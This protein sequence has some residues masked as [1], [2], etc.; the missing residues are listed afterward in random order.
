V[1]Y[2]LLRLLRDGHR[3]LVVLS[4]DDQSIYAFRRADVHFVRPAAAMTAI[5]GALIDVRSSSPTMG[6]LYGGRYAISWTSKS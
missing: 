2:Q 4:D 3:N 6:S 1:Q 5:A